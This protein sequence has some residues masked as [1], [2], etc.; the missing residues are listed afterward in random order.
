[1]AED[2]NLN[3]EEGKKLNETFMDDNPYYVNVREN[4]NKIGPGMCL[5]KW[6]QVTMHLQLGHTHSCHHPK[7]HLISQSE[8]KRNPTALHN[9]RFKKLKRKE[10]LEGE[11][12]TECDYCWNVEDNSDRFSDRVFKSAESWSLPHHDAITKLDWR[13]DYNPKYVEVAFSN[14]CN[15]KCSYCS[16][17][18]ST[19]WMEEIEK[20]GAYPTTDKFNDLEYAITE[21]K[22]PFKQTEHNPYVE[23][24]WKWWPD[25]YKDLHTFRI[26]GGEPL[27]SKDTWGV[28]DYIIENPNPNRELN[29]AINSNLGVPD[30]LID[31]F[32]DKVSRICDENRVNEFVIFTSVDTWGEQ[33]EYIRSGL[34]FNQFWDNVNKLLTK[35]PRVN[36]TFM[37]TY[38]AMSVPNY[39]KLIDG[40]YQLKREYGSNDRY[41]NSAVFLDTSYLRYPTHQ[42]VQILPQDFSGNIFKQAQLADYLGVPLFDNKYIGYSDIEI[43]K[44]KRTYDW[45]ISAKQD[46]KL[47]RNQYNF[48][49]FVDEHD[50]RRGTDFIKTFPEFEEFYNF[51]NTITL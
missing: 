38:N 32:I 42:T 48:K 2:I 35:C 44:L 14:A 22:M 6:T 39:H 47:L 49:K 40:I 10:M 12:P 25:L 31:R 46:E 1:M 50:K 36:L 17:A 4:L 24:F 23:A 8:I 19:K 26:T 34:V 21:N 29:L 27:M 9:T 30:K 51:C 11:R 5:A 3:N 37:S 16:P 15:F 7:T 20:H 43:Q 13:A 45:M 18:F 33:A 41:W 28:L